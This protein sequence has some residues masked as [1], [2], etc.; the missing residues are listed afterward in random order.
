[1]LDYILLSP[2]K[3]EANYIEQTLRS[4]CAQTILP[5][6]WLILN[7]G[8]TDRTPA[9]IQEYAD[10]HAW[11][12]LITL[13]N[14]RPDLTSTGGRS[15][16]VLNYAREL[17]QAEAVDFVVKIDSDVA[18]AP[19]FFEQVFTAFQQEKSLGLASGH[20]VQDGIPEK[21][22]DW[23]GVRGATRIYR[24]ACFDA[25]GPYH[26]IRGE[27]EIDTY[28]A[29]MKGWQTR[30]LPIHFDHLK[31]EG[32]RHH[33]LVN[34]YDTG[35]FKA[36]IPYR[37]DFFLL[38]LFKYAFTKPFFIGSLVQLAAYIK[39]RWIQLDRPFAQDLTHYVQ[40]GQRLKMKSALGRN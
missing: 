4:V 33:S 19:S 17:I 7:D 28:M 37:F 5:K 2:T 16:A 31:P 29:R 26:T 3:N 8:S 12:E 13:T 25:V 30:T 20:L 6:R 24:K 27:D 11:I 1:M 21:I 35:V 23:S 36:R 22:S 40:Q 32:V 9:I 14:F 34:H 15:G 18:F 39:I 10:K 38:T